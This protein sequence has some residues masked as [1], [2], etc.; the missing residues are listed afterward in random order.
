M[1]DHGETSKTI[2]IDLSGDDLPA[3]GNIDF[4]GIES[5][6]LSIPLPSFGVTNSHIDLC[7]D[8]L[9]ASWALEKLA[10]HAESI[11]IEV[12]S[13]YFQPKITACL[14]GIGKG[15]PEVVGDC[16]LA[17]GEPDCPSDD[18][19]FQIQRIRDEIADF[20]DELP[21]LNAA[22][23][24]IVDWYYAN[25]MAAIDELKY[26]APEYYG[27]QIGKFPEWELDFFKSAYSSRLGGESY[28]SPNGWILPV[29]TDMNNFFM[30][31]G[32]K[33]KFSEFMAAHTLSFGEMQILIAEDVLAVLS[34]SRLLQSRACAGILRHR[35]DDDI[36]MF[37]WMGS[38]FPEAAF[39][40]KLPGTFNGDSC[41]VAG[42]YLIHAS[43]TLAIV[44]DGHFRH[45]IYD[46]APL[47]RHE[48]GIL[49]D[50]VSGI[51]LDVSTLVFGQVAINCDWQSLSDEGFEQL[52]YDIIYDHPRFDSGTIRKL[53]KSR[54]R[55]GGR[56][57]EVYE[58]AKW[59][60]DR[61][62]KK[63]IFQCKLVKGTGSLGAAKV[64]DVGDMLERYGAHGFGV[65]TS[66][67]IDATLYDKLD[68]ICGRRNVSQMHKSVHELERDLARNARLRERYFPS[69]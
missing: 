43:G 22:L 66:T 36:G 57:I 25:M 41:D 5:V 20:E 35:S 34:A 12:G 67:V 8:L 29:S 69:K 13:G 62:K 27:E 39:R 56:D 23:P 40:S 48:M 47:T 21:S 31:T 53:G 37:E 50:R 7:A 45:L 55:D 65:F 9:D 61:L 42:G 63:W 33:Y 59:P 60:G 10:L 4:D 16:I 38:T 54:S 51:A 11:E 3:L 30:V 14:R 44:N 1:Q 15:L 28:A 2:R 64:T 46:V 52:C 19:Y 18:L 32:Q 17:F 49:N 6:V 58:D 26:E 24:E 68:D